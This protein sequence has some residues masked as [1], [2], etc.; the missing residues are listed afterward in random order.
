MIFL[1]SSIQIFYTKVAISEWLFHLIDSGR[2]SHLWAERQIFFKV[3]DEK[4][5]NQLLDPIV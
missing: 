3:L 2:F 5:S 4:P 1:D